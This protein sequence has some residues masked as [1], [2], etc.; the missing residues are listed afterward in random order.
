MTSWTDV[1]GQAGWGAAV[2]WERLATSVCWERLARGKREGRRR[3]LEKVRIGIQISDQYL[4][5]PVIA[6]ILHAGRVPRPM[7]A[8]YALVTDAKSD[9]AA[10][11]IAVHVPCHP[12][13]NSVVSVP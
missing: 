6:K 9:F 13:L 10:A 3:R 11:V 12:I 8:G 2:G 1:A 4:V 5:L 7:L